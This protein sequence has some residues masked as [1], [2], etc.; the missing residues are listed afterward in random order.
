MSHLRLDI[1]YDLYFVFGRFYYIMFCSY[2][3]RVDGG[4]VREYSQ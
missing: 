3:P 1:P 4:N 2:R